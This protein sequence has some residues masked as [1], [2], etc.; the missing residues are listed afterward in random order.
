MSPR[1][2]QSL[3]SLLMHPPEAGSGGGPSAAVSA[4]LLPDQQHQRSQQL[5]TQP[6]AAALMMQSEEGGSSAHDCVP[7]LL[8]PRSRLRD[9]QCT[10]AQP[11]SGG[12]TATAAHFSSLGGTS[13]SVPS[14]TAGSTTAKWGLMQGGVKHSALSQPHP[15]LP[16]GGSSGRCSGAS[17][18]VVMGGGGGSC[19]EMTGLGLRH[20]EWPD[21]QHAHG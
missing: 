6:P 7:A 12:A 2:A 17:G 19:T 18:M 14:A 13:Q 11:S 10:S 21:S 15:W 9:S 8:P 20:E 3:G 1:T 4:Q 16:L 5:L